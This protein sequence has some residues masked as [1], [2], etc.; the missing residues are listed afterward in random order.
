[1]WTVG[2]I[3]GGWIGVFDF[4]LAKKNELLI[5]IYLIIIFAREHVLVPERIGKTCPNFSGV[6]DR[7]GRQKFLGPWASAEVFRRQRH[8]VEVTA[9]HMGPKWPELPMGVAAIYSPQ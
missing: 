4:I 1:M 3:I 7:K 2:T 8:R 5:Y 9:R 6:V